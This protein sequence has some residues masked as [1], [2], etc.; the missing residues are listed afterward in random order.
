[1]RRDEASL[2]DAAKFANNVLELMEG[3]DR[4]TLET[5]LRTQSAV[6]YQLTILGF[7]LG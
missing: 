7:S 4:A 2:L 1:M 6:L 3:I 5:D